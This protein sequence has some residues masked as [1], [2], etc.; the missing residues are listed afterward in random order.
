M[1]RAD[2]ILKENVYVTTQKAEPAYLLVLIDVL[3]TGVALCVFALF[4]HVLPQALKGDN[5]EINRPS[6][7]ALAAL[8]TLKLGFLPGFF[9]S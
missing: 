3:L 2:L 5:I 1:R 9:L 6:T 4:H 8:H 7:A